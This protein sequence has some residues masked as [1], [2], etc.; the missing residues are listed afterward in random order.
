MNS[1]EK[2]VESELRYSGVGQIARSV[3]NIEQSEAWY[4]GAVGLT[5]LFT[6]DKLAFFDCGGTRLMLSEGE[7]EPTDE[8]L[9]YLRVP[10]ME[11]AHAR[12]QERGIEFVSAPHMIHKHENGVE[13]RM[14]FF[15][16]LEGRPL[17]IMSSVE[18]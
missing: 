8:S 3:R 13:E 5:H 18:P 17:A 12:L 16:D 15:N 6:F 7:S 4:R 2:N 10:D 9:L 1:G 14:A 11:S